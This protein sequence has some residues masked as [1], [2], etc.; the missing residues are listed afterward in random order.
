MRIYTYILKMND[1]R[2]YT[3]ITKNLKERLKQHNDGRSISTRRFLPV[4]L[5]HFEIYPS[6]KLARKVEVLIKS[7]GAR[8]YMIKKNIDANEKKFL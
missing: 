4:K 2:Y 6:Y 3:G 5:I 1:N 8:R 7:F